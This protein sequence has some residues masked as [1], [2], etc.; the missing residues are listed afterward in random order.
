MGNAYPFVAV[1]VQIWIIFWMGIALWKAAHYD[2]KLWFVG[3]LVCSGISM[4]LLPIAYLFFFAKK[5]FS[6]RELKNWKVWKKTPK[7][8]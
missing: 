3:I 5:K 4:G 1:V 7:S 6:L 8:S 2:Q